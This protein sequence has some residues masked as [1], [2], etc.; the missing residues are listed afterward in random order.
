MSAQGLRVGSG[1][2]VGVMG[3][4]VGIHWSLGVSA[5]IVLALTLG[6]LAY[7]TS[8]KPEPGVI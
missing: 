3:A 8:R 5:A 7:V 1:V 6:L 2:S 4:Y